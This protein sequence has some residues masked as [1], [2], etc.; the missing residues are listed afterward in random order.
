MRLAGY[1]HLLRA[2]DR[3]QWDQE[4]IDLRPDAARWPALDPARRERVRDL[5]AGFALA[6]AA[7]A[8]H[9]EPIERAASGLLAE[10]LARQAADERRHAAFF[11][12]VQG[13]LTGPGNVRPELHALFCE[14]LPARAAAATENLSGAV[15]FYHLVL[16]GVVF[17]AGQAALVDAA[18]DLPGLADGAARVQ[19]DERWHVGLGVMALSEIGFEPSDLD[20]LT[21]RAG[22]CWTD[23]RI[24]IA[25]HQRRLA[26]AT[27][28]PGAR[29]RPSGA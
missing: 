12:R 5:V 24:D 21:E 27:S 11:A 28:R 1:D 16:E 19:A 29:A 18:A 3:L 8:D 20:D 10:C 17:A 25:V 2:A 15:G 13:Q 23:E 7:V 9:L 22:H 6:E 14:E 4:A 26:L